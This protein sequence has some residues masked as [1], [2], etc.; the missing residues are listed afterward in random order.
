[1]VTWLTWSNDGRLQA[2]PMYIS[3]VTQQKPWTFYPRRPPSTL[4]LAT[5]WWLIVRMR[6]VSAVILSQASTREAMIV[7]EQTG[8]SFAS[9]ALTGD[10][11]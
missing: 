7:Q 4:H 9:A 2:R 11:F 10:R 1:M 6:I 8:S 3:T 5:A